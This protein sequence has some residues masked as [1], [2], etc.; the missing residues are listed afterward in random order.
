MIRY[1]SCVPCGERF[2]LHEED[3]REGWHA[4]KRIGLS[5]KPRKDHGLT[6]HAGGETT[7]IPMEDFVCDYCNCKIPEVT[8][9]ILVTMWKEPESVPGDWE[10]DYVSVFTSAL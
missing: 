4:R 8:D 1:V 9:I 7:F 10:N 5:K 2:K 3:A 6:I